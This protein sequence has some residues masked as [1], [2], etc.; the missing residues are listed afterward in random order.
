MARLRL[1]F[2]PRI[3]G[4][5]SHRIFGKQ[6]S[7]RPLGMPDHWLG[8]LREA[9]GTARAGHDWLWDYS[10]TVSGTTRKSDDWLACEVRAGD[11]QGS[12]RVQS[13]KQDGKGGVMGDVTALALKW[14]RDGWDW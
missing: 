10:L 1:C 14:L 5:S 7:L 3:S 9:L 12:G 2:R 13:R 11:G 4:S 6:E 8:L